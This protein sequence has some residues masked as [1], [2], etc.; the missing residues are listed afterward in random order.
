[1]R[2][3]VPLLL[4]VAVACG[5]P[6]DRPAVGC[7]IAAMATPSSVIAQFGIP[8]QTLSRAPAELPSRLVARVAGGG[9]FSAIVG[10]TTEADSSLL[11]GVE[12]QPPEGMALGFGVLLVTPSGS[13][14]GV[15][16]F[17]GLPV[18]GAPTI[19]TV[20]MGS[21][22]APLLGVEADPA[23]Y[24]DPACPLFPDSALR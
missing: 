17:E 2:N 7:G 9:S 18:E 21:S 10:R 11:V 23:A 24:E 1:M 3:A 4:S 8:E 12:G 6:G 20:S 15:M 22:S 19:G 13:A 14:R 5:A 16:L